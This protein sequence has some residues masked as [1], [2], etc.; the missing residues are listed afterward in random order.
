MHSRPATTFLLVLLSALCMNDD[1]IQ[2]NGGDDSSTNM[3]PVAIATATPT[4]GEAPLTVSFDGTSSLDPD[5]DVITWS[6]EFGDGQTAEG[7]TTHHTY[8]TPAHFV[9]VLT[10]RDERGAASSVSLTVN[11]ALTAGEGLAAC[12][13]AVSS[14]DPASGVY[15]AWSYQFESVPGLTGAAGDGRVAISESGERIALIAGWHAYL[16]GRDGSEPIWTYSTLDKG[17]DLMSCGAMSRSG[18]S[19][20]VG[21]CS[22]IR[23]FECDS[24]TPKWVFSVD[25]D[26][27]CL[28]DTAISHDGSY[29][30]AAEQLHN[31]VYLFRRDSNVPIQVFDVP[32]E[33]GVQLKNVEISGDGTRIVAGTIIG[34]AS[35]AEMFVFDRNQ[36]LWTHATDYQEQRSEADMPIAV[37]DDGSRIASVGGDRRLYFFAGSSTPLWSVECPIVESAFTG[38]RYSFY[39][40]NMSDA[41][42]Q[43]LVAGP[44][45]CWYYNDT[46]RSSPTWIFDGQYRPP[47]PALFSGAPCDESNASP[48][49]YHIAD[50]M[51]PTTAIS[52]DGAFIAVDTS[53]VGEEPAG[54]LCL[55]RGLNKPFRM[56]DA[57]WGPRGSVVLSADGAW[58]ATSGLDG[59]LRLWEIAPA[60]VIEIGVPVTVTVSGA[61]GANEVIDLDDIHFT[62]HLVK[63]G[64]AA[65][66][67]EKWTLWAMVGGVMMPPGLDWLSGGTTE[68]EHTL[69]LPAGNYYV[70]SEESMKVPGLFASF[71]S[72]VTLFELR[73]ELLDVS[74]D[75]RFSDDWEVFAQVQLGVGTP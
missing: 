73:A 2:Q 66:L 47:D 16:F 63:P 11:V 60:E 62:R 39:H 70:A 26:E 69:D 48:C 21:S 25:P 23:F 41:G 22:R 3:P 38:D 45:Q 6:W 44:G 64:R 74:D 57:G 42:T 5:G 67:H 1:C 30:V 17:A 37:S 36:L 52:A 9:A 68:E 8:V 27:E 56:Y 35:G 19:L 28:V 24:G 65:S 14:T 7:A 61:P 10:V 46:S 54:I 58:L 43:L 29:V 31:R 15:R 71:V 75:V 53:G 33:R 12:T 34:H 40:L 59:Q 49:Q 51:L 20:V 32:V 4:S 55:Y 50:G 72:T 18:A 13:P